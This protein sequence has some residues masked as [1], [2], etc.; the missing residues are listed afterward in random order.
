MDMSILLD[1]IS[2][3]PN[4]KGMDLPQGVSKEATKLDGKSVGG[5]D[6][7]LEKA[8]SQDKPK[9][10]VSDSSRREPVSEKNVSSDSK[11]VGSNENKE[12]KDDLKASVENAS[13]KEEQAVEASNSESDSGI[14]SVSSQENVDLAQLDDA[15]LEEKLAAFLAQMGIKPELIDKIVSNDKLKAELVQNIQSLEKIN[16][17]PELKSDIQNVIKQWVAAESS[18]NDQLGAVALKQAVKSPEIQKI[19]QEAGLKLDPEQALSEKSEISLK[20]LEQIKSLNQ[21]IESLVK[22]F[23]AQKNAALQPNKNSVDEAQLKSLVRSVSESKAKPMELSLNNEE[24]VASE[25]PVDRP[26]RF[27][28]LIDGLFVQK[29]LNH[30]TADQQ[31]IQFSK[32]EFQNVSGELRSDSKLVRTNL[33]EDMQAHIAKSLITKEGGEISLRLR[34]G[35]LGDVKLNIQVDAGSVRIQME[36]DKASASQML[37]SQVSELKQQLS[38][39]GLKVDDISISQSKQSAAQDEQRHSNLDQRQEQQGNQHQRQKQESNED[40]SSLFSDY[41]DEILSRKNV[42]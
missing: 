16:A 39:A 8:S 19:M 26:A 3:S 11:T 34:P 40:S 5:F 24:A 12:I 42:A 32:N 13:G 4:S 9:A 10:D 7:R 33:F 37:K 28:D 15:Q 14:E 1:R 38:A 18:K 41:E 17:I 31:L 29:G 27:K 2:A 6:E 25:M 21:R 22:D 20:P 36:T 35:N 30:Q 23:V